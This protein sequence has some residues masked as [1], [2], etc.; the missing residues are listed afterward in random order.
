MA[1]PHGSFSASWLPGQLLPKAPSQLLSFPGRIQNGP[2]PGLCMGRSPHL[3]CLSMRT[4]FSPPGRQ[5]TLSR[6]APFAPG[7]DMVVIGRFLG[8]VLS[9]G[10]LSLP[11]LSLV[12]CLGFQAR[13]G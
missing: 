4:Q 11:P 12:T 13:Q 3:E 9:K 7:G 10:G 2:P 6:K 5:L 8:R 1:A